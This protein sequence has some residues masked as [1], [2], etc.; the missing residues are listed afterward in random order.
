VQANWISLCSIFPLILILSGCAGC[1]LRSII[2]SSPSTTNRYRTR[3]IVFRLVPRFHPLN[4]SRF[5]TNDLCCASMTTSPKRSLMMRRNWSHLIALG[6]ILFS[7]PSQHAY[8]TEPAF[9]SLDS[10]GRENRLT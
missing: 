1:G 4:I 7:I 3:A 10:H 8:T 6:A 9:S 2:A 5:R